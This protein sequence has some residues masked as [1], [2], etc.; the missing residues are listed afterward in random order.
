MIA[1]GDLVLAYY[2]KARASADLARQDT[3]DSRQEW[4]DALSA[5]RRYEQVVEQATE[6]A[7]EPARRLSKN[8][9]SKFIS[10][11]HQMVLRISSLIKVVSLLARTYGKKRRILGQPSRNAARL[12][13]AVIQ[14]HVAGGDKDTALNVL[15]ALEAEGEPNLLLEVLLEEARLLE[16][17]S[18][19][20]AER[21]TRSVSNL[22]ALK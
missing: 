14:A 9:F 11:C 18:D 12:L 3:G 21:C 20:D 10:P 15:R 17:R 5:F 13:G 22:G 7:A 6:P 2:H 1:P 19:P 4:R 16:L 8:S